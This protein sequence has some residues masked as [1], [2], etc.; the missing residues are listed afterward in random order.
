MR[1]NA[2]PGLDGLFS[3]QTGGEHDA[4]VGGIGT[5]SDGGDEHIAMADS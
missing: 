2:E 1:R 5:T 4:G 3:Q